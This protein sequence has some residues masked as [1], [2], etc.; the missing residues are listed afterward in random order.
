M[1]ELREFHAIRH[2][3]RRPLASSVLSRRLPHHPHSVSAG[4]FAAIVTSP[5]YNLGIRYRSYEDTLPA[6]GI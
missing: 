4:A 5:P 3:R 2:D 1:M 6:T